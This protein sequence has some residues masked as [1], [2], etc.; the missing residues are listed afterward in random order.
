[1]KKLIYGDTFPRL[2]DRVRSQP[3]LW[4]SRLVLLLAPWVCFWMVEILNQNDVF[5]DLEAWQVL[6]N[7]IWYYLL[8]IVCRL[9][10]G[11]NR[12]AHG[13]AL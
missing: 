11:R 7:M 2:W 8:L 12:R 10:L 4:C 13:G 6:M 1:M 3:G 5:A 9:I